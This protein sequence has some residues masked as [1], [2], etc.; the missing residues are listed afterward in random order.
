[1]TCASRTS[2]VRPQ[3]QL[4]CQCTRPARLD[5]RSIATNRPKR[6]P[7][8]RGA[9]IMVG[10]LIGI[11]VVLIVLGLIVWAVTQ[12]LPLIPLPEPFSRII[13]VLIVLLCSLVV[14]WVILQI[15][16]SVVALPTWLHLK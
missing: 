2:Q 13:H 5:A 8:R 4:N 11:I 9:C 10:T 15:L 12:L 3:S 14:I 16:G 7:R 1:R 6:S